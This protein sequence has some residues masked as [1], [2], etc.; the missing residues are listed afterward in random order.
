MVFLN[1][2]DFKLLVMYY[3][4]FFSMA[5]AFSSVPPP[6]CLKKVNSY[7][8]WMGKNA[9]STNCAYNVEN[10]TF[11][12]CNCA[13]CE[14]AFDFDS[15]Y[16]PISTAKSF[17][18]GLYR[19]CWVHKFEERV[20]TDEQ[21][22]QLLPDIKDNLPKVKDMLMGYYINHHKTG[23]PAPCSCCWMSLYR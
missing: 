21:F 18:L 20:L 10:P 5:E 23:K 13:F 8:K 9:H 1:K 15:I 19:E 7:F 11:Y 3:Y 14:N 2:I 6:I 17:L 16:F 12:P 22:R 4:S